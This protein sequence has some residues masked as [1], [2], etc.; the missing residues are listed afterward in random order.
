VLLE[1]EFSGARARL[2]PYYILIM[3]H[4]PPF[5]RKTIP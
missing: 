4:A 3:A 1:P 2:N 5:L